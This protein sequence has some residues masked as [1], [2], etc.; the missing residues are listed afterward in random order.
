MADKTWIIVEDDQG[1]MTM[2]TAMCTIWNIEPIKLIDGFAAM[3]WIEKFKDGKYTGLTP[4]L[5]LLDIRMPGP[6]GPEIASQL[7]KIPELKEMAIVMMTAFRL[8]PDE[9]QQVMTKSEADLLL[10]KPLPKLFELNRMVLQAIEA[11]KAK[12][13]EKVKEEEKKEEKKGT[14]T[15]AKS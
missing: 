5:A 1:V 6:Q 7:R 2:V 13:K 8:S 12:V 10:Y 3:Q 14:D 9:K 15:L 4:E 11:R